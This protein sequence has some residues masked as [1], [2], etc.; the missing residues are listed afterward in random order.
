MH[1]CQILGGDEEG[2][3]ETHFVDLC[4]GLAEAGDKVSVIAHE[5]YRKRMAA[6]IDYL[7]LNLSRGR[8]NPFLR[9]SLRALIESAQ[10][11]IVH[12][13]AGKAS[14]L[15]AAVRCRAPVVGTIHAL[16]KDLS[17]YHGFNAVIGVSQGV[18]KAL[19]HPHKTVIP[20]GVHDSDATLTRSELRQRFGIDDNGP[21]TLAVGRLV[22]VKGF[23]RLINQWQAGLGHLLIV[24]DGPERIKLERLA[25]GKAVILA[26]YQADA[27]ALMSAADLLV[28]SSEREGFSYALAEALHARLPVV[29]TLV[30]GAEDVLPESHLVPVE[31]LGATIDRCLTDL[32][33]ARSRMATAF[34]W[35]AQTLT[36]ERMVA[37]TRQVYRDVLTNRN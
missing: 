36:I 21:V 22:P 17:P 4:N 23:D 31:E 29:S 2:G 16:K 1:V 12:A 33:A 14:A 28:F 18:L 30:P 8:R 11:D 10:P 5:H 26:G 6:S 9:R 25:A 35:A 37:A 15:T 20:N 34:D 24:G 32:P 7:P 27:R 13:H 3:L 19:D